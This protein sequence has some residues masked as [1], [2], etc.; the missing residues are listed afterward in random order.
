MKQHNEKVIKAL[1]ALMILAG[2]VL[3]LG[4]A[5]EI[6]GCDLDR[7]LGLY[8]D[9]VDEEFGDM[10]ILFMIT[11]FPLLVLAA[12]GLFFY[13][14]LAA[15]ALGAGLG[16][17]LM[18]VLAVLSLLAIRRDSPRQQRKG[19]R[20]AGAGLILGFLAAVCLVLLNLFHISVE[21]VP[22]QPWGLLSLSLCGAGTVLLIPSSVLYC[23]LQVPAEEPKAR[24]P[25][26]WKDWDQVPTPGKGD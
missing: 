10:M 17:V 5:A 15:M 2:V 6:S 26:N 13:G 25:E 22:L 12:V 20:F 11:V 14:L 18:A 19:K 4:V 21:V 16:S 23:R 24:I 8:R 3:G 7:L 1:G 9:L